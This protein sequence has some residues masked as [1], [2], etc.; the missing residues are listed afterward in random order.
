MIDCFSYP[1]SVEQEIINITY[2]KE[3]SD[4]ILENITEK[5]T[6]TELVMEG[7]GIS[8]EILKDILA[9]FLLKCSV[10][11]SFR[12]DLSFLKHVHLR[13]IPVS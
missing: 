7:N 3:G 9:I 2:S 11:C 4:L 5:I 6:T 1:L 8:L 12:D 10:T 13:N